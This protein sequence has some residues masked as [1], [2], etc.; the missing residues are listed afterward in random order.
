MRISWRR[1]ANRGDMDD[2]PVPEALCAQSSYH[3]DT[4]AEE[5]ETGF[6]ECE[7]VDVTENN[8]ERFESQI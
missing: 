1:N 5:G 2:V 4:H 3:T 8:R 7:S 6:L